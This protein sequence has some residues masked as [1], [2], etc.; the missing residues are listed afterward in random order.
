MRVQRK[1]LRDLAVRVAHKMLPG[2][3]GRMVADILSGMMAA[4]LDTACAPAA[5]RTFSREF[6]RQTDQLAAT[7][8]RLSSVLRQANGPAGALSPPIM[9]GSLTAPAGAGDADPPAEAG[10]RPPGGEMADW[11]PRVA[12]ESRTLVSDLEYLVR[13]S[14]ELA[15]GLARA[16]PAEKDDPARPVDDCPDLGPWSMS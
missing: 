6:T 15:A 11:L 3:A 8:Q 4:L 10:G 2:E 16:L 14:R 9:T 7:G 13:H 1:D 12:D 5:A